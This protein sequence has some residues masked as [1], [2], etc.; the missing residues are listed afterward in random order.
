MLDRRPDACAHIHRA[1]Q[2]TGA[3]PIT[4]ALV[5][6]AAALAAGDRTAAENLAATFEA[7]GCPYQQARTVVLAQFI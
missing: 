2:A 4:Y 1:R 7:L 6:R 3:N 5:E